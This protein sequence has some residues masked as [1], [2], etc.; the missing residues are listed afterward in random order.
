MHTAPVV[1]APTVPAP[2][3]PAP[4]MHEPEAFSANKRARH[5]SRVWWRGISGLPMHLEQSRDFADF[6]S[7]AHDAMQRAERAAIS[8]SSSAAT[9]AIKS[10]LVDAAAAAEA[11]WIAHAAEIDQNESMASVRDASTERMSSDDLAF[12]VVALSRR[13]AMRIGRNCETSAE[14]PR[15]PTFASA[16]D[17]PGALVA[18]AAVASG[19]L[20]QY[21][22][23]AMLR[24]LDAAVRALSTRPVDDSL[25]EFGDLLA[26]V[27]ADMVSRELDPARLDVPGTAQRRVVDQSRATPQ[28]RGSS[29]PPRTS[30]VSSPS[31]TLSP[32]SSLAPFH[33]L[34]TA[35]DVD[36]SAPTEP[37]I[38]TEPISRNV[39]APLIS[40]CG[41]PQP[42][43]CRHQQP[44]AEPTA[45]P[46]AKPIT[47]RELIQSTAETAMATA[48]T[49]TPPTIT[50]QPSTREHQ[51]LMAVPQIVAQLATAPL[52]VPLQTTCGNQQS[53]SPETEEEPPG[54]VSANSCSEISTGARVSRTVVFASRQLISEF[55]PRF[56][57]LYLA[58]WCSAALSPTWT[59][60]DLASAIGTSTARIA[61]AG[62]ASAEL[63]DMLASVSASDGAIRAIV[64][65][66]F[67]ELRLA[68]AVHPAD[69][70]IFISRR[71]HDQ[72]DA[73]TIVAGVRGKRCLAAC[74]H[75]AHSDAS[76]FI[77]D[78]AL[79]TRTWTSSGGALP[80]RA[81][82][83]QPEQSS[84][85]RPL[86]S[87]ATPTPPPPC[88]AEGTGRYSRKAVA[89]CR[90]I[91]T[92][93]E[94]AATL[95]AF[96]AVTSGRHGFAWSST[97]CVATRDLPA[98]VASGRLLDLSATPI[99]ASVSGSFAVIHAGRAFPVASLPIAI[100]VWAEIVRHSRGSLATVL[101]PLPPCID[102]PNPIVPTPIVPSATVPGTRSPL[103]QLGNSHPGSAPLSMDSAH[104][105]QCRSPIAELSQGQMQTGSL[106]IPL[107]YHGR[108]PTVRSP[109][110]LSVDLAPNLTDGRSRLSHSPHRLP[111]PRRRPSLAAAGACSP[112]QRS[113][114]RQTSST[115]QSTTAPIG[116]AAS[117]V[118][119]QSFSPCPSVVSPTSERDMSSPGIPSRPHHS[120]PS[121]MFR[122]AGCL[123]PQT[124]LCADQ[125][126]PPGTVHNM[127]QICTAIAACVDA[128]LGI[129]PSGSWAPYTGCSAAVNCDGLIADI[130]L[131]GAIDPVTR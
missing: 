80:L 71:A 91:T 37:L 113:P 24:T 17:I 78:A 22:A 26:L 108:S 6:A 92:V 15:D 94:D 72:T 16:L 52:A 118:N 85:P 106:P 60:H 54:A 39:D 102:S 41:C 62:L 20:A 84:S 43:T 86:L 129:R 116:V 126:K 121:A 111:L 40:N 105:L 103:P 19:P 46:T 131:D 31:S 76:E 9:S 27:A 63:L 34:A 66:S 101:P 11:Y 44:T 68:L 33:P 120:T 83:S 10:E 75:D 124:P 82:S 7:W 95:A 12:L 32:P 59:T 56:R 55:A 2:M 69:A 110:T 90:K 8:P 65:S 107:E 117:P 51:Q 13:A 119:T 5:E 38:P 1:P 29:T 48:P 49:A 128:A 47:A 100:V 67:P 50:P 97:F 4:M 104:V 35:L 123:P 45:K 87:T 109:P 93:R 98:L 127:A 114:A 74:L 96:D 112:I 30:A 57:A 21:T 18:R 77:R 36:M 130:T 28:L 81:S 88:A 3:V 70:A 99:V 115:S 42:T 73:R 23:S 53:A 79:R 58:G 14:H 89:E 25:F 61:A 125:A 64:D 122:S